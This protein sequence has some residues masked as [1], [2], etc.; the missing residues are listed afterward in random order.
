MLFRAD[1]CDL[2]VQEIL[3]AKKAMLLTKLVK[4]IP[5][6]CTSHV[7]VSVFKIEFCFIIFELGSLFQDTMMAQFKL[8]EQ[9]RMNLDQSAL[10]GT[11]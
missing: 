8:C 2:D 6:F 10:H 4:I 9:N 1:S 3:N 5:F 7:K 11:M